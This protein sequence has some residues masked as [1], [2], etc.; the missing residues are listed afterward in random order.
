MLKGLWTLLITGVLL[1]PVVFFG[2]LAG[3]AVYFSL[4]FEQ[5][6]TLAFDYH[7]YLLFFVLSA[8]YVYV[9]RKSYN[10][11]YTKIAWGATFAN[12]IKHF[13][14]MV[15]AFAMGIL[16]GNYF[17]FSGLKTPQ[18]PPQVS[19]FSEY[20]RLLE[21]QNQYKD[22]ENNYNDRLTNQK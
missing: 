20:S 5:I 16:G 7:L 4:D 3:V 12:M 2:A 1:N 8:L 17:D 14:L 13:L 11:E 15:F 19:D 21:M 9:F 10:E 6:Q 22:W 18:T